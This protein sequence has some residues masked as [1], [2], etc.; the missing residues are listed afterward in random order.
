M[1]NLGYEDRKEILIIKCCFQWERDLQCGESFVERGEIFLAGG[2]SSSA[3][4]TVSQSIQR[5][6]SNSHVSLKPQQLGQNCLTVYLLKTVPITSISRLIYSSTA[7]EYSNGNHYKNA[8]PRK[9]TSIRGVVTENNMVLAPM[10]FLARI[11]AVL[12]SIEMGSCSLG[13]RYPGSHTDAEFLLN[14][15]SV[16]PDSLPMGHRQTEDLIPVMGSMLEHNYEMVLDD[17]IYRGFMSMAAGS[18]SSTFDALFRDEIISDQVW[19]DRKNRLLATL[20]LDNGATFQGLSTKVFLQPSCSYPYL[21]FP[22]FV[23]SAERSSLEK[24]GLFVSVEEQQRIM[25]AAM[26]ELSSTDAHRFFDFSVENGRHFVLGGLSFI[27]GESSVDFSLYDSGGFVASISRD[28]GEHRTR[29]DA[30]RWTWRCAKSSLLQALKTFAEHPTLGGKDDDGVIE[31]AWNIM[32]GELNASCKNTSF[33]Y[34]YRWQFQARQK[35]GNCQY[36]AFSAALHDVQHPVTYRLSRIS[37]FLSTFFF[38]LDRYNSARHR[39][40]CFAGRPEAEL[41]PEDL[42]AIGSSQQLSPAVHKRILSEHMKSQILEN[43]TRG[44]IVGFRHSGKNERGVVTGIDP[45]QKLYEIFVPHNFAT[46]SGQWERGAFSRRKPISGGGTSKED[47]GSY[48]GGRRVALEESLTGLDGMESSDRRL[49]DL[50]DYDGE[51]CRSSWLLLGEAFARVLRHSKKLAKEWCGDTG[52]R[53]FREVQHYEEASKRKLV[54]FAG[55]FRDVTMAQKLLAL[56]AD[57]NLLLRADDLESQMGN[58]RQQFESL[59]KAEGPGTFDTKGFLQGLCTTLGSTASPGVDSS[60]DNSPSGAN[61]VNGGSHGPQ[62][63]GNDCSS[64]CIVVSL[65]MVVVALGGVT[66]LVV[67]CGRWKVEDDDA[68][69]GEESAL[70]SSGETF[71]SSGE[72]FGDDLLIGREGERS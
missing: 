39:A 37:M 50:V 68:P 49:L 52:A 70:V 25:E 72:T 48:E 59:R 60:P 67:F 58:L 27:T 1:L 41:L 9:D 2:G 65:I 22:F 34:D 63:S 18:F 55:N 45:G 10:E 44:E 64:P 30:T 19:E 4:R 61:P 54:E 15:L 11:V 47:S 71:V 40:R 16:T 26:E 23:D 46:V 31:K 5:C 38:Y 62:T 66:L 32:R 57:E 43:F 21:G 8:V 33:K 20:S 28:N 29:K 6:E 17:Q 14:R 13:G 3:P 12:L 69:E 24:I 53:F 42:R 7:G 51:P 56:L 35:A 36:E